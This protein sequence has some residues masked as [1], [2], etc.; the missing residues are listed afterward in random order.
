[1]A[2]NHAV[3]TLTLEEKL[4][5]FKERFFGF[6]NYITGHPFKAFYDMKVEGKGDLLVPTIFLIIHGLVGILRFVY[7][8]FLANQNDPYDLNIFWILVQNVA[9]ILLFVVAN[10]SITTLM[11][12]SGSMRDI[13]QVMGY[14]L[15]L[16]IPLNL[17]SIFL[18]N[19]L[20]ADEM[21]FALFFSSLGIVIYV[22]YSFIGLVTVHDF[23]FLR[24][25]GAVLLTFLAMLVILFLAL[26]M[27]TLLGEVGL[28]VRTVYHELVLNLS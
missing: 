4:K 18:T 15:Y 27:V 2:T 10:W 9:P 28:F 17:L 22:I 8:G 13:Y 12:G 14:S 26:L 11:D 25:V 19:I 5:G 6:P 24:A 21:P 1:M 3:N 20:I 23:T 16:T 7:T